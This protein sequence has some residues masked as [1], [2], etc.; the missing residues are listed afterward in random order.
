MLLK[1]QLKGVLTAAAC[2]SL[3]GAGITVNAEDVMQNGITIGGIDVS[4][5]TYEEA[6]E[7]VERHVSEMQDDALNVY[8]GEDVAY[9]T[10]EELGFQWKNRD[11]IEE[12][13]KIGNQGNIVSRY[14]G[15]K[16]LAEN[17]KSFELEFN[18]N[19]K[20][21]RN[22]IAEKCMQYEKSPVEASISADGS[23]GINLEAGQDGLTIDVEESVTV[24]KDYLENNLENNGSVSLAVDTDPI[25]SKEELASITDQLGTYTTL[26]GSTYGRNTNVER[27]AEL[28]NGHLLKP[29]ES[30]SVC[31]HLVPF[32]A[33][34]GY[35]L[36]GEYE[37]GRVVQGYG[38][39]IC[40]VSTTLYNALLEAELQIDERHNHTMSVSYVPTSMD[41]AI[42]EGAMDLVFTNNKETP[43]F[44]SGYAYNGEITFTIWGKET[45]PA[46]RYVSYY[47]ETTSTIPDAGITQLFAAEDQNVGYF[48]QVQFAQP[49]STAVLYKSVTYNGETTV[50]VVNESTYDATPNAY[51]VGTIG[52]SDVLLN[53][54]YN[55][56]LAT[57]QLAATGAVAVQ[58]PATTQ[59]ITGYD[60]ITGAPIY[61][62]TTVQPQTTYTDPNAGA[63]TYTD[64]SV[65]SYDVGGYVDTTGGEV[66]VG[67]QV[68]Y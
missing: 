24:L 29:G 6:K 13:F 15:T 45:R 60:P 53:A 31:E 47:S 7:A 9:T 67:E 49:G 68:Y 8:V 4:G 21:I 57:A 38:G 39:G 5:M 61:G 18:A 66:Y 51:E 54:I 11:V 64:P 58:T 32:S 59:V 3:L 1:K 10:A 52:A 46:D 25:A 36:G 41:A 12:A 34:N 56:D 62:D 35:E 33:E 55:N 40:Q 19:E 16:E 26:Y 17:K 65:G 42:A 22:F 20:M 48:N 14:K 44:I 2:M 50:E 37:N 27:G 23:G 63:V 30:F 43:I 28:I